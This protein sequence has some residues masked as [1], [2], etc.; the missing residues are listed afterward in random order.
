MSFGRDI[1]VLL[2]VSVA[3]VALG[4]CRAGPA[5]PRSDQAAQSA[6]PEKAT[7]PAKPGPDVAE[8]IDFASDFHLSDLCKAELQEMRFK[9][10]QSYDFIYDSGLPVRVSGSYA[11]VLA[12]GAG[13]AAT[14]YDEVEATIFRDIEIE[15]EAKQAAP[16]FSFDTWA[17]PFAVSDHPF[18]AHRQLRHQRAMG[19][20][21]PF[22]DLARIPF[23]DADDVDQPFPKGNNFSRNFISVLNFL[24][25]RGENIWGRGDGFDARQKARELRLGTTGTKYERAQV[26]SSKFLDVLRNV[27][28]KEK[29]A[30]AYVGDDIVA[31]LGKP[32]IIAAAISTID[33]AVGFTEC[34]RSN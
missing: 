31:H 5:E 23:H 13:S 26:I 8:P 7:Q 14:I 20:T 22:L 1:S 10:F 34:T 16:H 3:T 15:V 19:A 33:D 18:S 27:P 32:I 2:C 9:K 12:K 21:F 6:R 17:M 25:T 11:E 24:A 29:I 30:I 4:A 28:P